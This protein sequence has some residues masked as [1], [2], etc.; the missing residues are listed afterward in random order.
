[1]NILFCFKNWMNPY[2]GGVPR[3]SDTLAKY[4]GDQGHIMFYLTHHRDICDAYHFPAKVFNLPN[5]DLFSRENLSYY[6]KLLKENLIDLIVNHDAS[7]DRSRFF[8]NIGNHPAKKISLYHTDPLNGLYTTSDFSG[9]ARKMLSEIFPK[10]IYSMKII[11]KRREIR[12]LLK[13]SDRLILLSEQFKQQISKE[14][15]IKSNKIQAISNPLLSYGQFIPEN[16]KKQILF[17]AR[18]DLLVKRPDKM[19][20]IWSVIQNRHP[21][22]EL[23]FLGDGQDRK[24]VED[25]AVSMKLLNVRFEGRVDPIPYYK[26]AS[27]I[28]MTSDYE[29]FGLVLLEGMQFG[30]IPV[31]F[32][33]WISLKDIIIDMVTGIIVPTND[34]QQYVEKISIL[35][36]DENMRM[37]FSYNAID[38]AK[39]FEIEKIGPK[40]I[41]LIEE[42]N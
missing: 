39:K 40:W 15:K 29:G 3:V 26:D 7:N 13:N 4:F 12:F 37:S 18:M 1:M 35:M 42:F 8:L 9:K 6:H 11:R 30:A 34:I 19:L 27:I 22:W 24:K 23:I 21:D 16:K 41:K 14:L 20:M 36:S 5:P 17:V 33:N 38:Q 25:M 2:N 32:N 31:A 28:C 10:V